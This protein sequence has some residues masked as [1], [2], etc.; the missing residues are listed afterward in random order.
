MRHYHQY[1]ELLQNNSQWVTE[2]LQRDPKYFEVL[3]EYQKPPFLYIGCSDSRVP[4]DTYTQTEPGEIFIHRNIANQIHQTDMNFL[5]V[6]EFAVEALQVQHIVVAG[7]Y[8]C[9]GIQGAYQNSLRGLKESWTNPIKDVIRDH[10][11]EL[12]Q[13]VDERDKLDRLAELNVV[14]QVKNLFKVPYLERLIEAGG[15][16][17]RVHGW[18]LDIRTGLVKDLP[19]PLDQWKAEGVLPSLYQDR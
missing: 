2:K 18:V 11:A 17:P 8:G 4:I 15:Y 7:H 12:D 9:G 19:L 5:S 3:A 6:L 13:Y 14:E 16:Y 10:R 1:N